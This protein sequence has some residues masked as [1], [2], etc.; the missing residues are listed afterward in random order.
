[1]LTAFICARQ[2]RGCWYFLRSRQRLAS[3]FYLYANAQHKVPAKCVSP[4]TMAIAE[5]PMH[6]GAVLGFAAR[7]NLLF[8]QDCVLFL[9]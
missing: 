4:V 6:M 9:G 8:L 5:V 1:M 7:L 3:H 2:L